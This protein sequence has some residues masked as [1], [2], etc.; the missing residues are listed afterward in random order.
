MEMELTIKALLNGIGQL[1]KKI[2]DLQIENEGLKKELR[3]Y[4]S[5]E[6]T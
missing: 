5:D 3:N 6:R 4:G 2:Q 1:K